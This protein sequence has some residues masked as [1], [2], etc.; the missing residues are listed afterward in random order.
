VSFIIDT[1][2]LLVIKPRA[3]RW[4][5]LKEGVSHSLSPEGPGLDKQSKYRSQSGTA[6]GLGGGSILSGIRTFDPVDSKYRS[7]LQGDKIRERGDECVLRESNS[8][9]GMLRLDSLVVT[10]TVTEAFG[11]IELGKSFSG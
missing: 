1:D 8:D 9:C 4:R 11:T 2:P 3:G 7:R 10:V 6:A 5:G